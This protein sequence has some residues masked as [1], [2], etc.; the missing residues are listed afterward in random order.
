M[1]QLFKHEDLQFGYE[2]VLASAYRGYADAGEVLSTAG[3][4]K[5]GDADAWVREWCALAERLEAD[6]Q[7]AEGEGR[8]VS[9]RNTYL[10]AANCYSAGL[11]LITHSSARERQPDIW[12][13]HRLG[14]ELASITTRHCKPPLGLAIRDTRVLDW[15][16][17]YLDPR[18]SRSWDGGCGGTG[19]AS[20]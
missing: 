3:R 13:P 19:S 9:A 7:R 10:R 15:L 1:R 4:V 17:P 6:A 8:R 2:I 16:D 12:T 18:G 5:D 14:D 11:Y 20:W